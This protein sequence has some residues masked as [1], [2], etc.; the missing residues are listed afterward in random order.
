MY[1]YPE[2]VFISLNLVNSPDVFYISVYKQLLY[3]Q[4]IQEY[5]PKI[6]SSI[7]SNL[8]LSSDCSAFEKV[9]FSLHICTCRMHGQNSIKFVLTVVI[10]WPSL[11]QKPWVSVGL[12]YAVAFGTWVF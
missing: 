6:N 8:R 3:I 11:A 10:F 5:R 2:D 1:F 7:L 4:G 9:G 12:A